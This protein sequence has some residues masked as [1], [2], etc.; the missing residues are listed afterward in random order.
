MLLVAMRCHIP[1]VHITRLGMIEIVSTHPQVGLDV[2]ANM[3][4]LACW[5]VRIYRC[6]PLWP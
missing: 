6:L 1:R 5:T 3:Q 2:I 4:S